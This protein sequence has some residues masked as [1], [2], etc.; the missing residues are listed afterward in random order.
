MN[1]VI[2]ILSPARGFQSAA[3]QHCASI[4]LDQSG[5]IWLSNNWSKLNPPAGS[6]GI[7]EI[8]GLAMLVCTPM[9]PLHVRPS[10]ATAIACPQQNA[11]PLAAAMP[12]SSVTPT[13]ARSCPRP[14]TPPPRSAATQLPPSAADAGPAW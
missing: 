10:A 6:M 3:F 1:S 13:A 12:A 4:Q 2:S 8:I 14:P 9:T 11:A 7:A 5:N